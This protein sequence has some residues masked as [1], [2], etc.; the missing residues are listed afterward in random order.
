MDRFMRFKHLDLNLLVVLD[1]LL[2]EHGVSRAAERL[3]LSQP[4]MSAALGRLRSYFNDEILVSH[5]KR[6]I[7]TAHAQGLA[8]LVR[9]TLADIDQLI[10]ASAV[11]D[12]ATSQRTFRIVASDYAT[13]VLL[14]PLLERLA[15]T[16]PHVC[17]DIA[18]PAPQ[19]MEQLDRGEIDLVIAP[20]QFLSAEHPT[21]L[22]VAERFVVVGW[23][24]NP[25][26]RRPLTEEAFFDHGHIAVAMIDTPS[27]AEQALAAH[28]RKRSIEVTAP[29]FLSVPWMLPNTLRLSVMHERLA[30][31]MVKRLPLVMSPMPFKFP[32]MREMVQHHGARAIDGGVQWL[33]RQIAASAAL[34]REESMQ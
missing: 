24:G 4:A 30:R 12:P 28:G 34:E 32:V 27:F 14:V 5:G 3:N 11:F 33:L 1:V 22:L 16:A 20:E 21:R 13:T 19:A 2:R 23:K 6:M 31:V 15:G 26:F 10:S 8:P 29:S 18:A 25:V 9:K 17:L 7:P